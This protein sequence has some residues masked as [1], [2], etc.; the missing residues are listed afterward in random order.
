LKNETVTGPLTVSIGGYVAELPVMVDNM[1]VGNVSNTKPLNMKVTE[2]NHTVKVC[3]GVLC[4]NDT[5]QIKFAQPVYLDFGNRLKLVM[6]VSEPTIRIADT[7]KSGNKVTVSVEFINPTKKDLTMSA[8]I[9]V[10]YSYVAP[11][12]RYRE[13][14]AVQSTASRTVK[15]GNRTV[16]NVT[17]TL[18]GGSA[19]ISEIPSIQDSS[20][21]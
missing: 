3:I 13:G 12:T 20:V 7:V 18:T 10:A 14:N 2:G 19:Y 16:Q 4:V 21:T 15:A 11:S 1:T 17:L 5:V 8:T 9:Q 6:D